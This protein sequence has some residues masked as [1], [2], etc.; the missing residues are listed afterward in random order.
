MLSDESWLR[1]RYLVDELSTTAI[2]A[3]ANCS[4][5]TVCNRLAGYGI[6]RR[7]RG[8]FTQ[9]RIDADG[10]ECTACGDYKAWN[11]YSPSKPTQPGGRYSVCKVCWNGTR[12]GGPGNRNGEYRA[13]AL[14]R[15]GITQAE[16]DWLLALQKGVCALHGGPETRKGALYLSVDHDHNCCPPVK[17]GQ[18]RCCKKCIR[19]LLCHDCNHMVGLAE[20]LGQAWR[21]PDYLGSRPF[22]GKGVVLMTPYS[23]PL[24]HS[25]GL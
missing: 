4:Q 10:R 22:M 7:P 3:L 23:E 12:G 2:A 19:G 25:C 20:K 9:S 16:Y 24:S 14:K 17:V 13:W 21:F 15:M 18:T 5:A 1:E 8:R 6:P 11:E